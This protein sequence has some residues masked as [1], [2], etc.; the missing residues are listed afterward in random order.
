[1]P[2]RLS[3]THAV[4]AHPGGELAGWPLIGRSEELEFLRAAR[5]RRRPSSI[6]VSGLPGV[7]KSRLVATALEE[8]EGEGW[9]VVHLR[10][11]KG[12]K[13]VAFA[14]FRAVVPVPAAKDLGEVV[15]AL[16]TALSG[17]R[18]AKGLL[19]VVDDAHD[20]D[21]A[22]AG[23]VHHAVVS[24]LAV[25]ALTLRSGAERPDALTALWK[26]GHAE[27]VELQG[28]SRPETATLTARVLGGQVEEAT[29]QRLWQLTDGNP[30]YLRE[31]LLSAEEAGTL[32][33]RNGTW[34]WR[35]E[36]RSGV[37]LREIV[38][39]RL[40][41]LDPDE[42]TAVELLSVARFLP[43]DLLAGLS[44]ST[45]V[46]KLESRALVEVERSGRRLEVCLAHPLYAEVVRAGMPALRA[47]STR[48]R[49][50]L[51]VQR[52][53]ARRAADR[54][55]LAWWSL[56]AGIATD[57][58]ALT[59][60]ADAVLWHQGREISDHL[61]DILAGTVLP[62][63]PP[64]R[65]EG[66]GD[67][68]LAV[69]LARAAYDSSHTIAAGAG[70]AMTLCWA[71]EVTEAARILAELQA[72]TPS[73][74]DHARLALALSEV[75]FWGE[76]RHAE[77]V[78]VLNEA[79]AAASAG[80]DRALQAELLG[81]VAGIELNTDRPIDALEHA[82]Q[83]A[84]TI[85]EEL[86][87][88]F[89]APAAAASLSHLGRCQEA[90]ELIDRAIPAA[91]ERGRHSMEVP[92]LLFT[93]AGTLGRA[94]RFAE[95]RELADSCHQ[96][97]LSIESLE[98][99]GLFGISAAETLLREGRPA[100]SARLFREAIG[101]LEERDVFGYL[102]WALA[103]LARARALLG[104]EAGA[105]Q[106]LARAEAATVGERYFDVWR[107]DA[108]AAVH[109]LAGRQAESV[110]AAR[111]GAAWGRRAH[112]P[113]EEALLLHRLA[114]LGATA[115][116]SERLDALTADT[117]SAFVGLL[118]AH[119]AAVQSGEPARLVEV[120]EVLAR[121]G[122]TFVAAEAAA[123]AVAVYERRH[124][125]RAA[126][127]TARRA[128]GLLERCEGSRSPLVDHLVM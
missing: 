55:N 101:L 82:R 56:D 88:S 60:A 8:A 122:A 114:R 97:A 70:L 46:E 13:A 61:E 71:G 69:R 77:A 17:R 27:R 95:A 112:M 25:A 96:V 89:V 128:V 24:G 6:V 100:S 93:K 72:V 103:G 121:A 58:V 37:R 108:A 124:E 22:S 63:R 53:G 87:E 113:V 40:G 126:L 127:T 117:D 12:L 9:G 15:A 115:E 1:M 18:G 65:S 43:V 109:A 73:G 102:R 76:H 59:Q 29:I 44:G 34:R 80:T 47:Q 42:L 85:G 125:A 23:F 111:E 120:S 90:I 75:M 26:D 57:P 36:F 50:A 64:D 62:G 41:R 116:A 5:R 106:A 10:S 4:V 19:L 79:I 48:R 49:L 78:A 51:A 14:P 83:A 30:L 11:S 81:K 107:F 33:R 7:G 119:A 54:V 105:T 84:E 32:Q 16:E 91:L 94:G 66:G 21:E 3:S 86:F 45:S 39:E 2:S 123:A 118:A 68:G 52:A 110:E 99:T 92:Q 38:A 98:G 67:A 104:D 35:G 74:D 31:V 28:L 20:L